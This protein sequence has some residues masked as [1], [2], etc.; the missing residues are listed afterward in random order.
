MIM[1]IALILFLLIPYFLIPAYLQLTGAPFKG[2][3][4]GFLYLWDYST[5]LGVASIVALAILC[6][7]VLLRR[8]EGQRVTT[9]GGTAS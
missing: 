9:K 2:K 7:E 8:R 4:E 3:G 5:L 1:D 6:L